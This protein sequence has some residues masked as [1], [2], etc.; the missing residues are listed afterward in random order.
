MAHDSL[1]IFTGVVMNTTDDIS[2]P[3]EVLN[4]L[5]C[6]LFDQGTIGQLASGILSAVLGTILASSAWLCL[7]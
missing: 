5:D 1:R 4:K 6:D 7:L 2:V 3:N